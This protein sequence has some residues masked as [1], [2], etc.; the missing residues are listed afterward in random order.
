MCSVSSVL[1]VIHRDN[2]HADVQLPVLHLKAPAKKPCSSSQAMEEISTTCRPFQR[3]AEV[4]DMDPVSLPYLPQFRLSP[5]SSGG[6]TAPQGVT[7][8][9]QEPAQPC[10]FAAS[11]RAQQGLWG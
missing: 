3:P 2:T 8:P 6:R 7:H 11:L 9:V 4:P 1:D 5:K 10:P